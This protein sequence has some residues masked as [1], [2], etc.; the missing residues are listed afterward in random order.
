MLDRR[1]LM[2]SAAG[3]G[4]A[5]AVPVW[6]VA[7]TTPSDA[8]ARLDALLTEWFYENVELSPTFATSL[9]IDK[10]ER[11]HLAGK[12]G[13]LSLAAHERDNAR[14]LARWVAIKDYPTDGLS[15]ASLVNLK[16]AQFNADNAA[17]RT[18]FPFIGNP[19]V[20][21]QRSG[22]YFST[23]DFLANQHRLET[24]ED[25][26]AFLSRLSAFAVALDQ[27]NDRIAHDAAV[28]VMR[29]RG[30]RHRFRRPSGRG[31]RNLER[32]ARRGG[33]RGRPTGAPAL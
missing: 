6:A 7:Q 16:V 33:A 24:A 31:L 22:S 12:L 14:A 21:S 17:R 8:D 19:Y 25:A 29:R 27:E 3:V 28:G 20:V 1:R 15:P 10:G 5:A 30:M 11:A 2:L 4:L 26:E 23:P 18:T 13:D 9:G 32:G